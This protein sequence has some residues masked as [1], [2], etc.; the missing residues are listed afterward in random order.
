[1]NPYNEDA[2]MR[3]KSEGC[4]LLVA[5]IGGTNSRFAIAVGKGGRTTLQQVTRFANADVEDFSTQLAR[6]V[7][8]LDRPH[9]ARA[10]IAVAG[11]TDGSSASLTNGRWQ[12]DAAG[13]MRDFGFADALL[14]N[15]FTALASG[16]HWLEASHT[17]RIKDGCPVI[18]APLCVIGPGTGLGVACVVSPGPGQTVIATEG[19]HV[20]LAPVTR[21]EWSIKQ[22]LHAQ[23]GTRV[24]AEHVLSG[25]GLRRIDAALRGE[26]ASLR[27]VASITDEAL[28]GG[29]SWG[30]RSVDLFLT[31][32]ARFAGNTVLSQGARGGVYIG[33]GILPRLLPTLDTRQFARD[34]SDKGVMTAY[35]D[36]LPVHVITDTDTALRGAAIAFQQT[37]DSA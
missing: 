27:P 34:F 28:G 36:A 12:F 20:D 14:I 31:L 33:G 9:P 17:R 37:R 21:Q 5:D 35:C 22:T 30:R 15:D 13:L 25:E 16:V 32:L 29:N 8:S 3:C 4:D 26:P 18:G 6:F 2:P 10:C 19:G 7:S 11:P 23:L 1:M 24:S